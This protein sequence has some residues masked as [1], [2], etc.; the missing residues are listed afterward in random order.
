MGGGQGIAF[1]CVEEKVI[2]EWGGGVRGQDLILKCSE[3]MAR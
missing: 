2:L 3:D 1:N